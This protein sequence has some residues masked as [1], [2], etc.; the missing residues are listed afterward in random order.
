LEKHREDNQRA[1]Q[2]LIE[3]FL[4]AS[5]AEVKVALYR[6]GIGKN[7]T[8]YI[9]CSV[10]VTT[11]K[12][13]SEYLG[14]HCYERKRGDVVYAEGNEVKGIENGILAF[15]GNDKEVERYLENLAR[16]KARTMFRELD[17]YLKL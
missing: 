2:E 17:D 7:G 13:H 10:E 9:C 1:M 8:H 11:D 12:F 6:S 16:K 14:Y 3:K 5:Q 15:L 4:N